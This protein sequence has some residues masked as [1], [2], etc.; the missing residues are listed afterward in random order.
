M[1]LNL[2]YKMSESAWGELKRIN[3]YITRTGWTYHIS[4]DGELYT[5]SMKTW[6]P[7]WVLTLDE[8]NCIGVT[9]RRSDGKA[10]Q[11]S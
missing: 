11:N 10:N 1:L 8:R 6:I 7:R 5:V 3:G 4:S 9:L 2:I